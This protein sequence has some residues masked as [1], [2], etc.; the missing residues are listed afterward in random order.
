MLMLLLPL[1][2]RLRHQRCQHWHQ[3]QNE[4]CHYQHYTTTI[5]IISSSSGV[6]S[7]IIIVIA[8]AFLIK[9]PGLKPKT[10]SP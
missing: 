10:L 7:I 1:V 9:P 8:E 5:I 3:R 6:I 4:C 2:L